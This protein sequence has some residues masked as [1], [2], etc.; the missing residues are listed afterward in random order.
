VSSADGAER[1]AQTKT[2]KARLFVPR[3]AAKPRVANSRSV[4]HIARRRGSQG[5]SAGAQGKVQG[6]PKAVPGLPGVGEAIPRREQ[7]QRESAGASPRPT[8]WFRRGRRLD[9]PR[10]MP[11]GRP[12]AAPYTRF[13]Q[14][15]KSPICLSI[16]G[17]DPIAPIGQDSPFVDGIPFIGKFG[18]REG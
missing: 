1:G 15:D 9:G 3:D 18:D 16:K 17:D 12:G 2:G 8:K 10:P 4:N 14:A 7:P 11:A 13:N 5:D 6:Q